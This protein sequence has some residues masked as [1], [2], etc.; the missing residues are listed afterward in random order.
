MPSSLTSLTPPPHHT[1]FL[2]VTD[3]ALFS[4]LSFLPQQRE[5]KKEDNDIDGGAVVKD[6]E[7][8]REEGHHYPSH[9]PPSRT[10]TRLQ[11]VFRSFS[12]I[13]NMKSLLAPARGGE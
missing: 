13:R 8:K 1:D 11:L 10:P 12:I 7:E 3:S 9:A 4:Y 6:E 5:L 2:S